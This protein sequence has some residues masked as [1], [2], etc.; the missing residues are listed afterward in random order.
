MYFGGRPC[1]LLLLFN[2][3]FHHPFL[4]VGT[5]STLA[6]IS[7]LTNSILPDHVR[8]RYSYWLK[9]NENIALN[10]KQTA[11]KGVNLPV[12]PPPG[13]S[14]EQVAIVRGSLSRHLFEGFVEVLKGVVADRKGT[15][16]SSSFR[17]YTAHLLLS[18]AEIV[19]SLDVNTLS[20]CE[21]LT[22]L[23][24]RLSARPV[25]AM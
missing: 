15:C 17:N 16:M 5:G 3:T 24:Y 23:P 11:G 18:E 12:L 13:V 21:K 9:S 2:I 19:S 22:R 10:I 8:Y 7:L 20:P 14:P 25:T 4:I 1:F 6:V